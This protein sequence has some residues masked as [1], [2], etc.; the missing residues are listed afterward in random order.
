MNIRLNSQFCN[1]EKKVNVQPLEIKK[2]P[3]QQNS[4]QI[5]S[6]WI[7][8]NINTFVS[9]KTVMHLEEDIKQGFWMQEF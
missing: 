4:Q 1:K 3:E 9:N 2:R 5:S 6:F 7:H 8:M